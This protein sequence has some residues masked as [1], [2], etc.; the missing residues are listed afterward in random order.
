M[1]QIAREAIVGVLVAPA[2][3]RYSPADAYCDRLGASGDGSRQ[4]Q[5]AQRRR[6]RAIESAAFHVMRV[7]ADTIDARMRRQIARPW[8]TD[9]RRDEG[10][11]NSGLPATHTH[12]HSSEPL[13]TRADAGNYRFVPVTLIEYCHLPTEIAIVCN[14]LQLA[15]EAYN[16]DEHRGNRQKQLVF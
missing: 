13:V 9:A 14:G 11:A 7:R 16:S 3:D 5:T 10:K 6:C 12:A 2:T 8:P 1:P 15:M 4:S